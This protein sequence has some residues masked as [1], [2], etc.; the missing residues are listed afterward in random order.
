M[1]FLLISANLALLL[2]L[3][4]IIYRRRESEAPEP[5]SI[6]IALVAAVAAGLLAFIAGFHFDSALLRFHPLPRPPLTPAEST[7]WAATGSRPARLIDSL[8]AGLDSAAI[9]FNAD[10]LMERNRAHG[11]Q[12]ILDPRKAAI[13]TVG[14]RVEASGPV[15]TRVIPK[16]D[17][18]EAHLEQ[19]SKFEIVARPP[20]RQRIGEITGSEWRWTVTPKEEGNQR[21]TLT[22]YALVAVDGDSLEPIAFK[23]LEYEL[24]VYVRTGD[25]V[26]AFLNRHLEWVVG[27]FL[28]PLIGAIWIAIKR[29]RGTPA[30]PPQ[31]SDHQQS[32][33]SIDRQEPLEEP[34]QNK[35]K[36]KKKQ[37]RKS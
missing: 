9:A 13:G 29:R 8:R 23:S 17:W 11:I 26:R 3:L 10:S 30:I 15:V 16:A 27:T 1:F 2:A 33:L 7:Q 28:I 25:R 14:E 32:P 21:L 37:S 34:R 18:M 6:T 12:L 4:T 24:E 5:R 20:V 36:R 19:T 31:P 22:I 35:N